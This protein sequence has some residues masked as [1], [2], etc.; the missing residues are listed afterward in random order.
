MKTLIVILI[1]ASFLQTTIL[2]IDL[3]LLVLI[4]RAYIKS[5]RANL[6]LAFAFGMLT[7]HLNLINLG[8]QTFVYLI[9][10]WT[11]GLLSGSRLAGNPFLV[12]PVSFLFLSLNDILTFLRMLEC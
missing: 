1:I 12:V 5:E 10:V 4:C 11:T 2:P 7:A 9:V 3:V 6:Y 8:F